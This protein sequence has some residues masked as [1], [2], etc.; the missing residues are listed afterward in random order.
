[1]SQLNVDKI[2]SLAGGGGTAEFQLEASGNFNFDSGTLYVDSTNN[3]IGVNQASPSVTL[4]LTGTDGIILPKG[5]TAERPG[6]PVEGLFRYNTED[7]TF[8]GYAYNE[9]EGVAQWGPIAGA[10]GG[11]TPDQSTDRYSEQYSVGAILRSN[12]TEAY[13]SFDGE[14][15]TG[16]ATARIWTHGYVGGGYQNSSPWRNVNRTVHSTDTTTNLGDKL[17]RSG[18]YM[19]GSWSDI[20]HWFHSMENT[21][22]GSSN[23]TSGFNMA[24]ETGIAHLSQWDMTVNRGSMGSMQDHVFAGGNSFLTGGGN[25]RTDVFNLKT[26]TMRTSG[27]PNDYP[28]GG[29]D[30]TWG[31]HGR[32]KGWHKRSGT[33]KGLEW[34][35]ESWVTWEHGPGGDGWK[36]CLP[37]MLGH[38]YCGTGNNNQNG[39]ARIDDITGINVRNIDFGRMGEENFQMGMRKGYCLGNYNGSQ[40]NQTFK[41]N[42][43]NDGATYLGGTTEPK[44]H[45][46]MSSAHCASA[47][48]VTSGQASYDYGTNIPNF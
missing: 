34:K 15:D 16:W 27:F 24:S 9:D 38:L 11:G 8:E 14:N 3:R 25:S 19:S 33:R 4:H 40:N 20:K 12:G 42:Y 26:E 37:S 18:A 30:P 5:T 21:Y 46:G 43:I 13:W 47:S 7:R 35:T 41:V 31:G 22:R 32:L 23:Y 1:M 10:G 39:N 45:G 48:S 44:G 6:S 29:D 2:V 17:D 28:D 36:K